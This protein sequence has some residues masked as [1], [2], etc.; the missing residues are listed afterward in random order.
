MRG[1]GFR[2]KDLFAQETV[3]AELEPSPRSKLAPLLRSLLSEAAGVRRPTPRREPRERRQAMTRITPDHLA[4]APSCYIRQ[5]TLTRVLNNHES[6]RRQYGLVE[7][8]HAL[9]WS[10]VEVI[11]DD[12]GRSGSG[13]L[14]Q[15]SR[16]SW[17]RSARGEWERWCPSRLRDLARNGRDWHTL[18]DFCGL[19]GT[20]IL[21]EDGVYDHAI[22]M[23]GCCWA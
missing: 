16:S 5:S 7:R 19:V 9:G 10:A 14:A 17:R 21:D 22:P 2:Q 3:T 1:M 23:I 6:Q 15:A 18:L 8:A 20:L 13:L 4:A 11:D 12:L